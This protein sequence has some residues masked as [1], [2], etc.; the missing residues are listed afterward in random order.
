MKQLS[1]LTVSASVLTISAST[2]SFNSIF[3]NSS[4]IHKNTQARSRN[5]PW[6]GTWDRFDISSVR[7]ESPEFLRKI[8]PPFHAAK[9]VT[10]FPHE[11]L[12]NRQARVCEF[13]L[14]GSA[15]MLSHGGSVAHARREE[16]RR[17]RRRNQEIAIHSATSG[18]P[19]IQISAAGARRSTA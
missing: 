15:R 16:I 3:N 18:F 5:M 1:A 14:D 10:E 2:L 12:R 4:F 11:W 6:R 13:S 8:F 7:A 9:K 17:E 19:R